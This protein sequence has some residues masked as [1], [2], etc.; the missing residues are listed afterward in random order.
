MYYPL[1]G[2]RTG[3]ALAQ[4]FSQTQ[5]TRAQDPLAHRVIRSALNLTV[6]LCN[7]CYFLPH[8][9]IF[10]DYR[11]SE[12]GELIQSVTHRDLLLIFEFFHIA[13]WGRELGS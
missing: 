13:N 8:A 5:S 10:C 7:D 11:S 6:A 9:R 4:G 2:A 12:I 3:L 1:L